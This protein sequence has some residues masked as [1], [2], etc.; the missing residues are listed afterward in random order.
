MEVLHSSYHV[1]L[2]T[3][4]GDDYPRHCGSSTAHRRDIEFQGDHNKATVLAATE[5]GVKQLYRV[6]EYSLGFFKNNRTRNK[7]EYSFIHGP[8]IYYRNLQFQGSSRQMVMCRLCG[9]HLFTSRE[10]PNDPPPNIPEKND[11]YS[12][13]SGLYHIIL[14]PLVCNF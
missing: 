4:G 14:K 11:C 8:Y 9:E 3:G 6:L 10:S 1:N 12:V 2:D 13:Q 5:L 7:S